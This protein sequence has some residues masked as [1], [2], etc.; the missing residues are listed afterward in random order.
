MEEPFVV[1]SRVRAKNR[2]GV[3]MSKLRS[4]FAV[5]SLGDPIAGERWRTGSSI[6][7]CC[8]GSVIGRGSGSGVVGWQP[9]LSLVVGSRGGVAS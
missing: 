5:A 2:V 8:I 4:E 6:G 7:K 3:G 1:P 9:W